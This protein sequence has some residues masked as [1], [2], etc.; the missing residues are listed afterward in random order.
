MFGSPKSGV[1][2]MID[3]VRI[4]NKVLS[5]EQIKNDYQNQVDGTEFSGGTE[6]ASPDFLTETFKAVPYVKSQDSEHL[7]TGTTLKAYYT[8]SPIK[9]D[10]VLNEEVWNKITPVPELLLRNGKSPTASSEVKILYDD[11]YIY[12]GSK[13]DEPK[14]NLLRASL[15]QH[16]LPIYNDDCLELILDTSNTPEA[17]YH[18]AGNLIGGIYDAKGHNP[19][20]FNS[21]NAVSIGKRFSDHWTLEFAIPFADLGVKPPLP[22]ERWGIRV[23]RERKPEAENSSYPRCASGPF[24]ARAFL[25]KLEFAGSLNEKKAVNVTL[26]ESRFMLGVNNLE[27][28]INNDSSVIK[29]FELQITPIKS[30]GSI[31]DEVKKNVGV[32][33]NTERNVVISVPITSTDIVQLAFLLK[34]GGETIWR[35][36]L[37]Q[38]FTAPPVA[39][40]DV[41]NLVNT[42]ES[43]L[44]YWKSINPAL[45]EALQKNILKIKDELANFDQ[46]IGNA[47][48]Q[49]EIV[50]LADCDRLAANINGFT[51]WHDKRRLLAWEVSPWESG[52]PYD[53]PHDFQKNVELKYRQAGNEWEFKALAVNGLIPGGALECRV[54]VSD[55]YD[56]QGNMINR[57]SMYVYKAPFIRN[58]AG[59]LVTDPL[60]EDDENLFTLRPG[61]S[62]RF[63]IGCHSAKIPPGR[64]SGTITIKPVDVKSYPRE[65]WTVVPF[66]VEVL[67]FSLPPTHEWP[68]DTYIWHSGLTPCADEVANVDFLHKHHI[69][70]VSTDRWRYDAGKPDNGYFRNPVPKSG[71]GLP[72]GSEYFD[73]NNISSNDVFLKA[74][75]EKKMKVLFAWN[76]CR[77]P[78]WVKLMSEHM[79]SLGY[80]YN[81]F[82][83][84]GMS[85]EFR[86]NA[87]P[88]YLPFHK[89]A[90]KV[91]PKVRW[92]ATFTTVPPPTGCTY[93]Q[94]D[95]VVKY[96][97]NPIL[98]NKHLWPREQSRSKKMQEWL[99]I[100]PELNTWI[101]RCSTSAQTWPLLSYYRFA[102]LNSRL[103]GAKGIAYWVLSSMI[104]NKAERNGKM[105]QTIPD[106]FFDQEEPDA[107]SFDGLCFYHPRK[108]VIPTKRFMA[109][110][111]GLE[112]YAMI[113]ML[114]KKIS[115]SSQYAEL[116][117]DAALLKLHETGNQETVDAWREKMLDA[118]SVL[119]K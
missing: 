111:E 29:N 8:T 76:I 52:S 18:F 33:P 1:M 106:S 10:G 64:Y 6:S 94:L 92:M 24:S 60:I 2:G 108:N 104:G 88:R 5:P 70:W 98:F 78:E 27:V 93:Q 39:R 90:F 73:P 114:Q 102:P 117:S 11:K 65:L 43:D 68:I 54:A 58:N 63:W 62:N 40:G 79:L 13:F 15:D 7:Y 119:S 38:G 86:A 112:D 37:Q 110:V 49:N 50:S 75:L 28:K 46:T 47:I 97:K 77:N 71:R 48:K 51:K 80:T 21:R 4:L 17:T 16:D 14:M 113:D 59:Q 105:V 101:Y 34:D 31:V 61:F 84:S 83:F 72:I 87:L 100:H 9:L 109:L 81:D 116:I 85:D 23:A 41:N 53:L 22:G 96:I 42:I 25:A 118:L 56:K 45:S 74:V 99:K 44:L 57:A 30:N 82:M 89:E 66:H 95:E 69:N 67:P 35:G 55:L 12:F 91:A 26:S 107:K 36:G 20:V 115:S 3:E 19:R 32:K 103:V